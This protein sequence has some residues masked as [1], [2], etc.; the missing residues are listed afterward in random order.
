MD[1]VVSLLD[2]Q[3]Y[4]L[5]EDLWRE[6]DERLTRPFT[7]RTGGLGFFTGSFPVLHVPVVRT[8]QLSML[9]QALWPQ[10][11]PCARGVSLY[12]ETDRWQ[13]HITLGHGD[14]GPERLA[15]VA[16]YLADRDFNWEVRVTNLALIHDTGQEQVPRHR[17]EFQM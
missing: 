8:L 10:V 12:Y 11:S 4:Q 16:R 6:L 13:P 17:Y 7:V 9:H 2:K 1:A 3:H 5:V 14:L 15:A